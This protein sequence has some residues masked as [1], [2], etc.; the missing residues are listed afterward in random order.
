MT[1]L[2]IWR[3]IAAFMIAGIFITTWSPS[4]TGNSTFSFLQELFHLS[5]EAAQFVNLIFRKGVHL[6]AYGVLASVLY[7]SF[8]NKPILKAFL[9]TVLVASIDE[10]MQVYIPQRTGTITDV[11]IDGIGACIALSIIA[12]I[13]HQKYKRKRFSNR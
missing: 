10:W 2:V 9:T 12:I 8:V 11:V 1:K 5:E 7:F 6:G 13:K 3:M 4:A